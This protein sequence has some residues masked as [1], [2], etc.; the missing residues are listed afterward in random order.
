MRV[1]TPS[2]LRMFPAWASP[3]YLS[4]LKKCFS[5]RNSSVFIAACVAVNAARRFVEPGPEPGFLCPFSSPAIMRGFFV[6]GP[7]PAPSFQRMP[8]T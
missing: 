3:K 6:F 1:K 5:A 7:T 2:R 4:V 8:V